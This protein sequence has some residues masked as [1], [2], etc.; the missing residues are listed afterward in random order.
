MEKFGRGE[1]IVLL[2]AGLAVELCRHQEDDPLLVLS[3]FFDVLGDNIA[4]I[5]AQR[6]L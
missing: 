3:A 4:L 5:V 6:V 2:A 1:A